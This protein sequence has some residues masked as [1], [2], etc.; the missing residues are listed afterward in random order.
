MTS[1][2]GL[3]RYNVLAH[4]M[5]ESSGTSLTASERFVYLAPEADALIAK[6][7]E[8]RDA[9]NKLLDIQREQHA[10]F[11]AMLQAELTAERARAEAAMKRIDCPVDPKDVID[12]GAGQP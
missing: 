5:I 12:G 4:E 7:R 9:L 11:A 2:D 10:Q 8:E 6:L 1:P 3:V